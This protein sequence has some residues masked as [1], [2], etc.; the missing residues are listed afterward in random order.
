M[1]TTNLTPDSLW[2]AFTDTLNSAIK[3][4][5]PAISVRN[6]QSRRTQNKTTYHKN[7]CNAMS[8]KH[9]LW[10]RH[11]QNPLNTNILLAYA[12]AQV[13]CRDLI[14]GFKVR[15]E[16]EIIH[17]KIMVLSIGM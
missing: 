13:K 5:V 4:F 11:R 9:C 10:K 6:K 2:G 12:A 15:K 16:R 1:L 8:R 14:T 17:S 7:V 3:N